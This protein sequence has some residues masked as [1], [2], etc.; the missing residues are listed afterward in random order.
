MLNQLA[1]IFK[2]KRSEMG[3]LS[4][5]SM[6]VKFKFDESNT[7]DPTDVGF[8]SLFDT[9]SMVEEFMLLANCAVA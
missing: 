8:Y 6:Q 4:L 1:K 7:H 3:A 5:A 2:K 9:N